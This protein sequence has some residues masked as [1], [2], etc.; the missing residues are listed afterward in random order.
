MDKILLSVRNRFLVPAVFVAGF[1]VWWLLCQAHYESYWNGTIYRVQTTDF[2]MLHHTLPQTLAAEILADRDD[3]V[4]KTLDSSFGLFGLVIT[5]PSGENILYKTDKIYHRQSWQAKLDPSSL[6][7]EGEPYDLITD[8]PTLEPLYEHKSPRSPQ[9][10][11]VFRPQ[12][13]KVLGRIYYVRSQP[14]SFSEDIGNF[15]LTGIFEFSGAK[16]GYFFITLTTIGFSLVV[17]LL[18][19]LRKRGLEIKQV[20]LEHARRELDIRK[21]AL[22]NLG[23]E[24]ATQKARKV[25]LEREADQA[26]K[27]ALGLKKSLERLK[28]ALSGSL[29][30]GGQNFAPG[31]IYQAEL[32]GG[33]PSRPS[34]AHPSKEPLN[35]QVK[36]RPPV[37]PPSSILEEIEVLI[38]ALSENAKT[39]RSQADVLSD[40][41]SA[42]EERQEEMKK[43][44]E[45]AFVRQPRLVAPPPAPSAP[46]SQAS[47]SS[48]AN[49]VAFPPGPGSAQVQP[50]KPIVAPPGQKG[51]PPPDII[52]MSPR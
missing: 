46:S 22:E 34:E 6:V 5:D 17:L 29:A 43:I 44:V 50:T 16:R 39:L 19:H 42:L 28:E 26:Y 13:A 27:R 36:I 23:N 49:G 18:I 48:G 15:M 14:P 25:W 51:P 4:Q 30:A 8:P 12:G 31:P 11:R 32:D 41:C 35:S 3:L 20:E 9:A 33:V 2:N 1:C 21:K 45:N 24:L 37:S 7:K 52:D 47:A 10:E 40:Y 38:P